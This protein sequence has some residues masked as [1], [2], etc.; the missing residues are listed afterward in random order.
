MGTDYYV[1]IQRTIDFIEDHISETLT[2]ERLAR[3]ANFSEYHFHRVFQTMVGDA[4][5]E[6]VR[7][8][9]LANAAHQIAHTDN[10]IIHIALDNG[11][12]SHENFTRAFKKLFGLT[13]RAYR[14]QGIRTP[15]YRKA[16]VL[17][18]KFNPYLGGMKMDY[19]IT[20]KPAF[21]LIGYEL[22]TSSRDGANLQEIPAFWSTYLQENKGARIP[23]RVP[24]GSMTELGIC[25]DFNMETGEFVYMIGVEA[26]H[27]DDVPADLGCREFPEETYAV[28]TT[29][30][31]AKEQ[32]SSSI[33]ST[34]KGIF[35]EWFPH[36]GYEHAGGAEFELYD[37]R[38]H[39]DKHEQLQMDIYVPI[40]K[41]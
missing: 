19:R 26:A 38:C 4:V 31:V 37:E 25:T 9:R 8:R 27:F 16:N 24:A 5:M 30:L 40:K 18:R 34:W 17:Q 10:K 14:Q 6:Y 41:K 7:K 20:T 1:Q 33:Q 21:K 2:L 12:Q 15:R 28:F 3:I 39:A 36:S 11:F 35:E 23:N 29:P 13:P 32:F 22:K